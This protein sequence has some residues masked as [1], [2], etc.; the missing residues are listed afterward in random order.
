MPELPE[1]ETVRKTLNR[2]VQGKV[3]K[4]VTIRYENIIQYPK[5]VEAF[6]MNIIGQ[7][8][9]HLDR[10]GKFLIFYLTDYSLIS[11]LRMEGKYAI[12]ESGEPYDKHTHVIFHF[13]DG[14]DLRY[15]DVRKFGTMHLYQKGEEFQLPPLNKLG[16]EPMDEEFTASYLYERCQKTTRVIKNVLLDQTI[17]AGLG[18]I[19][20]DEALFRS[21]IYPTT[22]AQALSLTDCTKLREQIIATLTDAIKAGGTTIRS[23]LNSLGE[24]GLFQLQLYVYGQTG[25]P[26]KH[27]GTFIEKTKVGGRGTHY[28]PTCQKVRK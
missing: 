1:V 20:V 8:I 27:C 12:F 4:D 7:R 22:P 24:I 25:K 10:K 5:E 28:C 6:R 26:C 13:E 21:G 11:H 23:Y 14:T 16:P 19:Y 17:V 2:I 9:E 15:K 18:N 3:I